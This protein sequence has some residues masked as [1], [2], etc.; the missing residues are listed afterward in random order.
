M[1]AKSPDKRTRLVEAAAKLVYERGFHRAALADIAA[2]ARVPLGNVYYYFKTKDA[3]GEALV[4]ERARRHEALRSTWDEHPDPKD[5][6]L[7]FIDMTVDS[8]SSLARSGC[9]VGS[10]CAELHK[11][12][13][14]LAKHAT[15]LF[16]AYLTWLEKQFRSLGQGD[17]SPDLA[18]HLMSALQG[19]ALLTHSFQ[20]PRFIE[21]EARRLKAW[22]RAL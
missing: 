4:A 20:S 14:P 7:A 13:G 5:R 12:G 15:G 18:A 6:L 8:R 2:A 11:D 22:I 16:A 3:L 9:P 1:R 17:E 21:R 10:L 19:A